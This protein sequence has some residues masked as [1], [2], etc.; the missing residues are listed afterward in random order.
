MHGMVLTMYN[1]TRQISLN[2]I[3]LHLKIVITWK[4][5]NVVSNSFLPHTLC[6]TT[7]NIQWKGSITTCGTF[8]KICGV[9]KHALYTGIYIAN[10]SIPWLRICRVTIREAETNI[11]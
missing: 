11:S 6:K 10:I 4:G 5:L 3:F 9:S 8:G 7:T 1:F 2:F